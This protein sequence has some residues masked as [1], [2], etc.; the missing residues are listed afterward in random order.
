MGDYKFLL[1]TVSNGTATISLNRPEVYNALNDE[2]TFEL[3][4]VFKA[5]ASDA[6]VR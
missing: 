2:L 1:F 6:A 5:V 4:D 3:Q